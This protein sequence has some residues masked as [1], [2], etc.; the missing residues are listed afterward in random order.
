VATQEHYRG[1]IVASAELMPQPL[2]RD[3][4]ADQRD[5]IIISGRGIHLLKDN[6]DY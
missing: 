6:Y 2:L 1:I 4:I 5:N 3:P